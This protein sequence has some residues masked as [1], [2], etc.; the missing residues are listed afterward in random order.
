MLI[1]NCRAFS[2]LETLNAVAIFS[3]IFILTLG[4]F[5][6]GDR[7]W[8]VT[9]ANVSNQYEA[10]RAISDME[11]KIRGCTDFTIHADDSVEFTLDGDT[12]GYRLEQVPSI[13]GTINP[14]PGKKYYIQESVNGVDT[15]RIAND[16]KSLEFSVDTSGKY[17]KVLIDIV[18]EKRTLTGE[19]VDFNL[20]QIAMLRNS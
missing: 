4:I 14:Y 16:I 5:A 6:A 13:P 19:K 12:V 20:R 11:R 18:A 15:R 9:D 3:V 17:D 10:R 8:T 7:L 2:I 1:K